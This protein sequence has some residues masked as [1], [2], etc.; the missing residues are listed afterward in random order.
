MKPIK[1][2]VDKPYKLQKTAINIY[3]CFVSF[4]YDA[5]IVNK[6]KQLSTR[7]FVPEKSCW[8]IPYNL[9][10]TLQNK[11]L[12]D[13]ECEITYNVDIEQQII[14]NLIPRSY[15]FKTKP[16]SYQID[17]INYGLNH[18]SWLLGDQ[19]GLGKTFQTIN[20]AVINKKFYNVKHCLII[21]G[22]NGLKYNWEEEIKIHS[23]ENSW[24]LGTRFGKNG[25]KKIGTSEDKLKDLSSLP[26]D[27]FI[28]TNIET[29]RQ[30]SYRKG[31]KIIFPIVDK[32]NE[33][34]KQGEIGMI[35]FDEA[36]KAK[37]PTSQQG[38]ALLKLDCNKKIALSGT[39]L[40]N[41]PLDLYTPLKWTS[42]INDSFY[43]FKNHYC[44]LGG[45]NGS[46][47]I[48]YK[49]LD[50]LQQIMQVA[51][52]RRLKD[53]VLDLPEKIKVTEYVE[54][55][56]EQKKVYNEVKTKLKQD[57][58][59]IILSNNPIAE[60]TRLR[61]ATAWTGILSSTIQVSA[62][63]DRLLELVNE[64][65]SNNDK[66]VIFSNWTS[67]TDVIKQKLIKYNPAYIT[68]EV[69]EIDR[70]I[71]MNRFQND[72]TCKIMIGTTGALGT[73]FTLTSAQTMIFMDSPWNRAIKEQAEDRIH[74]IGTKGAVS[75]IT[76]CTKN[77]ID[78]IIEDIVYNKGKMSDLIIDGKISKEHIGTIIN[79]ILK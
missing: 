71:E 65:I 28:I 46:E 1:I 51:M 36:H 58:D 49:N 76:L 16:Y 32:I 62:K 24:I 41:N 17:G 66:V 52:L 21:C 26:D 20:L 50:E 63:M 45:F 22:V 64:A 67:V 54:M 35:I 11:T 3:S 43:M 70:K 77:T 79:T 2:V 31:N 73:G 60:L 33:L 48:S 9:L 74:R 4:D 75:I 57:I 5:E 72:S 68:G 18:N 40:M 69:N 29:L 8:E 34:C 27:Y 47:V 7:I 37:N 78:E 19:Q 13:Y 55:E 23:N 59:K 25:K 15:E 30:L 10:G 42:Y 14:K 61:Q 53:E 12:K 38:K 44:T 39:F 56:Q 6:I